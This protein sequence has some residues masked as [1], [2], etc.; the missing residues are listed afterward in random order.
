R[1]KPTLASWGPLWIPGVKW[2]LVA[3]I[4]TSEA[5]API[6]RLHRDLFIVGALALLVVIVTG[7]WLSRSLMGPLRELT[8]DVRRFAAGDYSAKVPVRPRH[9]IGQVR[10]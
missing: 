8:A 1:G 6:Y 4:E 2:A 7:A 10:S 9:E 5:F 3:K